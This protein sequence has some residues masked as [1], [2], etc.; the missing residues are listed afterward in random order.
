MHD[1][2]HQV[3]TFKRKVEAL[4]WTDI[5]V[6]KIHQPDARIIPSTPLPLHIGFHHLA[7][8]HPIQLAHQKP[9]ILLELIQHLFPADKNIFRDLRDLMTG[10]VSHGGLQIGSLNSHRRHRAAP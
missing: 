3:A 9:G 5:V 10:I 1:T 8:S 7:L 2:L 4:V 6:L